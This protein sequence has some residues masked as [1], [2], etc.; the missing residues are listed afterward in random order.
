MERNVT[1]K[2]HIIKGYSKEDALALDG[3]DS[4]QHLRSE[5]IIPT[6]GDLKRKTISRSDAPSDSQEEPSIYLCGNS[7]GLQP[8]RTSAFVNAHLGAWATKG[9]FGHFKV[10]EDSKMPPFVDVDELAAQQMAP[11]VGAKASEV[12]I[13]ETLSANLHLM[14]ASFYQPTQERYKIILEGKAFPSDYYAVE[15]QIRHHN[16]D[17][18]QAMILIEPSDPDQSIVTTAHIMSVID[19]HAS[20]TALILLPGVQ[21]YT[22][23]FFD[24]PTITAHAHAHGIIIG[25]D[26][27]HA[28]GNVDL[29]LHDWDVNFAVWCSYKYLNC[30]PGAIGGL[31]V[32]EKH[33]QVDRAAMSN[34]SAGFRARLSGWWGGDKATRFQMGNHF[35]PIPGAAGF[36]VGNPCALA[37]APLL[38]SLEIFALTSMAE[39]RCK[40]IRLTNFLEELL[41]QQ[42]SRIAEGGSGKLYHIVTPSK[43]PD[44]GAQL[45]IRLKPGLLERVMAELEEQGVVVDERKPDV[46]RVAPAPLYN[47]FQ[48][49]WDFVN[50][51]GRACLKASQGQVHVGESPTAFAGMGEKGWSQIK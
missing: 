47:T 21:Y 4:L 42:S 28:V 46:V 18:G 45:S 32:H 44:R 51:F 26:L 23:Q 2:E 12:A 29:Q 3:S 43:V 49:V 20:S 39:L 31:F 13:M 17:P 9:V 24:I 38:A 22:G 30:G 8:R 37:I 34:G 25:W 27:A 11:I 36:Q 16:F 7:L 35:V 1:R 41:D 5:F 19:K 40:S 10:L 48:E 6:K 15:S 14:M 50:I 33:G